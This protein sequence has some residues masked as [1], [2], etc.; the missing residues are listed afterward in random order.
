MFKFLLSKNKKFV[1][2]N[3]VYAQAYAELE[4]KNIHV[5]SM[6]RALVK[7]EGN[8]EKA[9]GFYIQE[10]FESLKAEMQIKQE[11]IK[12][13]VGSHQNDS[14]KNLL[15]SIQMILG[16]IRHTL[17]LHIREGFVKIARRLSNKV[18]FIVSIVNLCKMVTVNKYRITNASRGTVNA[19]R[20]QSH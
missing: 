7:A 11:K 15:K 10:R 17:T 12:L 19:R 9:I 13:M 18:E 5:A 16:Y 20:F 4:S 3:E 8:Q 1:A 2:D 14:G 6:A